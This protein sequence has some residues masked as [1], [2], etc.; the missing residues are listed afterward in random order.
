MKAWQKFLDEIAE[1]LG[2]D[3]VNRWL[4]TLK[5]INF[6]ACNLYLEARDAFQVLWFEEH[7]R[8]KV[9]Q[10]FLNNNGKIIKV[11]LVLSDG[12]SDKPAAKISRKKAD[13]QHQKHSYDFDD[14]DPSCVFESFVSSEDN[15]FAYRLLSELAGFDYNI[16]KPTS[17]KMAL[18]TFNPI[19]I[20]GGSGVGKTHLLMATAALLKE[21]N[22]K[23]V[24]LRAATFID[25]VIKAMRSG[26]ME[27]FRKIYRSADVLIIDDVSLFARKGACQE[28]LFHTFNTLHQAEKQIILSS[29]VYPRGLKYI[30]PRL[31]SRFE[32]GV[33]VPVGG[34]K[35]EDMAE[36]VINKSK[37]LDFSIDNEVVNFLCE[38][39][40][41]NTEALSRALKALVLR[42]HL[43]GTLQ[44]F[45]LVTVQHLLGDL[46]DV[47]RQE[48]LTSSTLIRTV[49][50]FYG[51]P[52][53]DIL[54]KSQSRECALPRQVA[55]H[56][57]RNLLNMPFM[58]IGDLFSRN[59]STVMTSVRQIQKKLDG[60]DKAIEAAVS[61][62]RQKIG[63][64][65]LPK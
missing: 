18:S 53:K 48:V 33:T 59:H 64:V 32:W 39:F 29:T 35:K 3:T 49:A 56:L 25:H 27:D 30:E 46:I 51:V 12:L 38:N 13:K 26:M 10:S 22:L 42:Q 44:S 58:T 55:M 31:I 45:D 21:Q 19:Y 2:P 52:Q 1:G 47:E 63:A 6:D 9:Q 61:G 15:L 5:V 17:P 65:Q 41:N 37:M 4:R 40:G 8:A 11:H 20:Y 62:I 57:C 7:V 23:V 54:G 16:K 36:L 28:E 60:K 43:G 14:L 24:Y 50:N 34:V